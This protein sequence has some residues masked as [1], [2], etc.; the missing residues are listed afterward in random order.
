M[1]TAASLAMSSFL[2]NTR[3]P[4]NKNQRIQLDFIPPECENL[5]SQSLI[6]GFVSNNAM[7][8]FFSNSLHADRKF[9]TGHY[10]D[11]NSL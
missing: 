1:Y 10:I 3:D 11:A 7:Y 2:F 9:S 8:R 5:F 4:R 6:G